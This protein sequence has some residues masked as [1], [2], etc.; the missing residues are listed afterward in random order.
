MPF[1]ALDAEDI[2]PTWGTFRMVRHALGGTAFG[3]NQIDFPP[4]KGRPEHD[5][6]ESGQEE[7]Y[8]CISG[9]GTLTIDGERAG[10]GADRRRPLAAERCVCRA[11]VSAQSSAFLSAPGIGAVVL[12]RHD[13]NGVRRC[14]GRAERRDR[15]TRRVSSSSSN[16]GRSRSPSQTAY[17]TPSGRLSAASC[18]S[19]PVVRA[20]AQAARNA[21]ELHCL[22]LLDQLELGD[23]LDVV[24]DREAAGRK[25]RVPVEAER[26][27]VDDRLELEA[28]ARRVAESRRPGR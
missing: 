15:R 2:E 13:Q 14:D 22:R 8:C 11:V 7:I 26:R 5:E 25:R 28:E 27:P 9:S 23:E 21:E 4:G 24:A 12:G 10:A 19:R 3:L 20:R 16:A 18:R 6:L 17:S 1:T